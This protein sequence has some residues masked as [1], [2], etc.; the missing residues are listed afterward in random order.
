ARVHTGAKAQAVVR[1]D[2]SGRAVKP[3]ADVVEAADELNGTEVDRD[4]A[5]ISEGQDKR[6][7]AIAEIQPDGAGTTPRRLHGMTP[8]VPVSDVEGMDV[9]FDDDVSRQHA[10]AAPEAQACLCRR[11]FRARLRI[12]AG[13]VIVE[14][15]E[16][17]LADFAAMNPG[18]GLLESRASAGLEI[19][20]ETCLA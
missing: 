13:A 20:Q 4:I 17:R 1:V 19:H 5:R 12:A 15:P 11:P 2:R 3:G 9:L 7:L 16:H 6:I 10:I 18:C 8:Q 14:M